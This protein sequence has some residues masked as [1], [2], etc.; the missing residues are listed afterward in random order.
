MK[1]AIV[2]KR[3]NRLKYHFINTS[4]VFLYGYQ[5]ISDGAKITYQIIDSFDWENKE[6]GD[7]KGYAFPATETLAK[8]R[9][10]SNRTIERHIKELEQAKLLTRLRRRNRPSI[11][12]IEDISQAEI[13]LYL[14]E[15]V[16]APQSTNQKKGSGGGPSRPLKKFST[17][18]NTT[19]PRKSR[20]DKNVGSQLLSQTTKMS[21]AINKKEEEKKEYKNVNVVKPKIPRKNGEMNSIGELLQTHQLPPHNKSQKPDYSLKRDYFA[22]QLADGLGDPQSLACYQVIVKKIPQ[23]I[24]FEKLRYVEETAKLGKIRKSPGALFVDLIKKYANTHGIELGFQS[25][26]TFQKPKQAG[27]RS[28]WRGF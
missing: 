22:R 19:S 21:I 20:N 9:H 3:R 28:P 11:L 26:A 4:K 2:F 25:E 17:P 10:T 1:E 24:L 8:I 6:T 15:Y 12:Y 5:N 7:S 27:G 16:D 23:N 18:K 13:D 14:A